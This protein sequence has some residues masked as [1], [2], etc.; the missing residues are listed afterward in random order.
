MYC[1]PLL[2]SATTSVSGRLLACL[3]CGLAVGDF[4]LVCPV[5]PGGWSGTRLNVESLLSSMTVVFVALMTVVSVETV[6]A[7]PITAV[8]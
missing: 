4:Y 8:A 3:L 6:V 7:I 2:A 5:Q 1:W